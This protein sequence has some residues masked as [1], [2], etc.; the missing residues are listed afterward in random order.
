MSQKMRKPRR[1]FGW[2]QAGGMACTPKCRV[3]ACDA[4]KIHAHAR[5]KPFR[6]GARHFSLRRN[7]SHGVSDFR[8]P[9]LFHRF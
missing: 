4:T 9:F 2:C 8:D 1:N 3:W 6:A 5:N 7:T